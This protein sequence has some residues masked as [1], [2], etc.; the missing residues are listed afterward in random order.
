[1]LP[2]RKA[3]RHQLVIICVLVHVINV[4]LCFICLFV[5]LCVVMDCCSHFWLLYALILKFEI[6]TCH[7][8]DWLNHQWPS[9]ILT[10]VQTWPTE[11]D[12]FCYRATSICLIGVFPQQ[13]VEILD[14]SAGLRCCGL[15]FSQ[16][17]KTP[18]ALDTLTGSMRELGHSGV[19][20]TWRTYGGPCNKVSLK[21]TGYSA[22]SGP[23]WGVWPL[24]ETARCMS[25]SLTFWVSRLHS[26]RKHS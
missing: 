16:R 23:D 24:E 20:I 19:V 25:W 17:L 1:M 10:R 4:L 14:I 22:L 6:M 15:S 26:D 11:K 7:F 13:P 18:L 12:V 8:N 21:H 5:C 2:H 3:Q 9:L